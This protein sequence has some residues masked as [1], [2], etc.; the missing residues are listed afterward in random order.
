MDVINWIDFL[1][2]HD[3]LETDGEGFGQLE[4]VRAFAFSKVI[5]E[6]EMISFSDHKRATFTDFLEML[7]RTA[8]A[9]TY[10]GLKKQARLEDK[11]ALCLKI[12]CR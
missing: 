5:T 1:D 11:L 12:V 8:D 2:R 6:D 3:L 4:A 7:C 9:R 10:K